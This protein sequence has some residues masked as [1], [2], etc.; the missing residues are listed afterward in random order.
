M[1]QR[2][3]RNQA[4]PEQKVRPE[5]AKRNGTPQ[6]EAADRPADAHVDQDGVAPGGPSKDPESGA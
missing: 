3:R 1:N 4:Q 2:T 5:T 6:D